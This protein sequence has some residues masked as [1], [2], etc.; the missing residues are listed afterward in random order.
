ML[1]LLLFP[2]LVCHSVELCVYVYLCGSV[3]PDIAAKV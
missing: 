2:L 3:I 1:S